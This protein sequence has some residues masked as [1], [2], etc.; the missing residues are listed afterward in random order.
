MLWP[1]GVF[2]ARRGL[3]AI[4]AVR[5]LVTAT[6][7]GV[8][9]F[10]PLAADRLHEPNAL[11]RKPTDLP[12]VAGKVPVAARRAIRGALPGGTT[13]VR[14]VH[15]TSGLGSLGRE[16]FVGI[17]ECEG[18]LVA[19]EA[20]ALG[21]SAAA[22]GARHARRRT[23]LGYRDTLRHAVRCPDPSLRIL[24]QWIVRR[25]A[26]DC[27]RLDLAA[28]PRKRDERGLLYAMGW[29]TANVH[30]GTQGAGKLKADLAGR[31]KAWLFRAA[32]K[33]YDV[34]RADWETW[35]AHT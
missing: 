26:P 14:L 32:E 24:R 2:R 9:S 5:F 1:A 33:L 21:P 19:R 4:V 12:T 18:G 20:K 16:R 35:R 27:C 17:G 8:D 7:L 31:P 34:I 28:L 23:W 22:R 25:L 29:E 15:R 6:F 3:P 10:I 30:L 11:W 13:D